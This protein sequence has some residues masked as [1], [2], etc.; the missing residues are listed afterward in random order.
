MLLQNKLTHSHE[1]S[2]NSV[3]NSIGA[4]WSG[5]ATA[6]SPGERCTRSIGWVRSSISSKRSAIPA[7]TSGSSSCGGTFWEQWPV[8]PRGGVAHQRL[9]GGPSRARRDRLR[10]EAPGAGR[11]QGPRS[12]DCRRGPDG[13]S[14]PGAAD[15]PGGQRS[16]WVACAL[17]GH[18]H[19]RGGGGACGVAGCEPM[20]EP[21]PGDRAKNVTRLSAGR[22]AQVACLLEVTARKPGNV[23]RFWRL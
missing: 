3:P 14:G 23:H 5:G 4:G 12:R 9:A 8:C 16:P 7:T 19:R 11:R 20:N 21:D 17:E 13:G 2:R 10:G 1:T 22:L 6:S 15:D 18:G